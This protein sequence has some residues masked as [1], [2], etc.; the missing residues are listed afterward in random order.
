[1]TRD[2]GRRF[3][4]QRMARESCHRDVP[5]RLSHL[6][7]ASPLA[8]VAAPSGRRPGCLGEGS[9]RPVRAPALAA[10]PAGRV[11]PAAMK[12]LPSVPFLIG[13]PGSTGV[14]CPRRRAPAGS[15]HVLGASSLSARWMR[16]RGW[17][18]ALQWTP[19][20]RRSAH[21]APAGPRSAVVGAQVKDRQIDDRPL[22]VQISAHLLA[23][24]AHDPPPQTGPAPSTT[25]TGVMPTQARQNSTVGHLGRRLSPIGMLA[26]RMRVID[27]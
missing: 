2:R 20:R 4:Q 24:L 25:T 21:R 17:R 7:C 8:S 22:V 10:A 27:P 1:M 18:D 6:N 3:L 15:N 14:A 26:V 13:R 9:Q 19:A 11:G 5:R 12:W 16:L 23:P